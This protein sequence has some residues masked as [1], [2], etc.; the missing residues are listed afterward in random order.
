MTEDEYD[1]PMLKIYTDYNGD[2][3]DLK[4]YLYDIDTKQVESIE[5]LLKKRYDAILSHYR[6]MKEIRESYPGLKKQEGKE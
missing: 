1:G 2:K 6:T 3:C 5:N 4:I